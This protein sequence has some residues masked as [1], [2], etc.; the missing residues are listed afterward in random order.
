[1]LVSKLLMP[2]LRDNPADAEV[3]SHKLMM[4]AGFIRKVA[5]GIYNYLPLGFKVIQNIERI[6]REEMN[7]VGA[8]ELL[9]PMVLPAELWQDSG[10]WDVY[11]KELLRLK[12]RHENNF[13][14]GPT[15]EEVI[16]DI[17]RKELRSYRQL[18]TSL[19]QIQ[20]KFRDEVR[21]RFGL[22][23]G[24][25]FIMKDCYS[26]DRDE[27]ASQKTYKVYYD[28]YTKIFSR[29]GLTYRAV[30]AVTGNIGGTLS[31]E[32]QVLA[33]SG[34]DAIVGCSGCD[35]AAN[36]EKAEC[37][38]NETCTRCGKGTM[39]AYRGIEVGQVFYL[40]T[41]YSKTMKAFY[42][43]EHGKEQLC[44]MGCYGIG[45]GRTAAA[46]I[47]QNHDDKGMIW[48]VALAP[49]KVAIISLG[50]EG[51]VVEV[52]Q[53]FYKELGSQNMDVLWDDR[54]ERAG[55]KFNDMD[56]IGIPFQLTIGNRGL[57]K[58]EVEIKNRKTGQ[59]ELVQL[60]QAISLLKFKLQI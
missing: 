8:Q 13:C 57:E 38:D 48:P 26:F 46:A 4:R 3:V 24:R 43:D 7:A 17:A 14:L 23:R 54:D 6:I 11:G 21:P 22:M 2:T 45:V 42:L 59:K 47:E 15:H 20:T 32:F 27:E 5:A 29:C 34:E 41:K 1:M 40:G 58:N 31:H 10:R 18:P 39:K 16:T 25:E 51:R 55:V 44:V 60:D 52:A 12:D 49:Y 33:E 9:M 19:Y 30:E 56:L 50:V 37:K 28:A 36:I 53:K 35:Y